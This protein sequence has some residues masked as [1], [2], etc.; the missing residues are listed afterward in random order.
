MCSVFELLVRVFVGDNDE[1]G[2]AFF[3]I[4]MVSTVL[5]IKLLQL[6]FFLFRILRFFL[7]NLTLTSGSVVSRFKLLWPWEESQFPLICLSQSREFLDTKKTGYSINLNST[8]LFIVFGLVILHKLIFSWWLGSFLFFTI[9]SQ[10]C[11]EVVNLPI[12]K[13]E[14]V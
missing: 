8:L 11:I 4:F 1:F 13:G 12:N 10:F 14:D 5:F 6:L 7:T 9:D 2:E 3:D